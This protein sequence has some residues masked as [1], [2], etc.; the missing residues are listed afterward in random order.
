MLKIAQEKNLVEFNLINLRNY[1]LGK[2]KTID[3]KAFGGGAGMVMMIEP[4]HSALKDLERK[5]IKGKVIL[6]S[7][8]GK[9]W[10]QQRANF[11]SQKKNLTFICGHYEGVDERVTQYLVDYE[12]RI[13]N[14]VLTGGEIA[15]LTMID[16]SVRLIKGVL[17]NQNS[18]KNESHSSKNFF[19]GPVYTRP[20]IFQNYQVPEVFFSGKHEEVKKIRK[21]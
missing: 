10:T 15:S 1:G 9:V 5:K 2:R 17:N 14:F 13:G 7:A 11:F 3:D 18:L 4:I 6:T 21:K 19:T 16:S 20:R 8:K 12:F